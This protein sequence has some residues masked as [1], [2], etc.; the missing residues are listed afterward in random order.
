MFRPTFL[1][2]VRATAVAQPATR[3]AVLP[4]FQPRFYS[5]VAESQP[6]T[7]TTTTPIQPTQPTT[8]PIQ[9]TQ[10]AAAA[11]PTE[12][13]PVP[14][15]Y[16]VGRAWTQRLPVYHLAKRGGNKKLTQIKKVQGDGQALRRDLAQLLGLDVKEVRVKVPTG[17]LEV[18]GHRSAEITKFLQGLGF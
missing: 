7:T 11:A 9:T 1:G 10:T 17:H 8:T 6:T 3:A 5:A 14:K 4:F 2:L 13:K 15:P 16:L 18:D 12:S